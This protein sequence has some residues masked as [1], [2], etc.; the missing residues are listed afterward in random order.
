MAEPI[1]V[2]R[3]DDAHLPLVQHL[4]YRVYVSEMGFALAGAD[5][6]ARRLISSTDSLGETFVLFRGDVLAATCQLIPLDGPGDLVPFEDWQIGQHLPDHAGQ[7][8]VVSKLVTDPQ[9]RGRDILNPLLERLMRAILGSGRRY[10]MIMAEPHL[11]EFYKALGFA[12]RATDL[13]IRPYGRVSFMVFDLE[14]PRHKAGT[15]LAGWMFKSAF[16][17]R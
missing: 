17:A 11:R 16:A 1:E 9:H 7:T 12:E 15:T 8:L 2:L 6:R 4:R 10:A 3:M 5:H 14:D 13:D